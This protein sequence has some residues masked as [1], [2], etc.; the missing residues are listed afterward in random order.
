ML[1][2]VHRKV[3]DKI[4]AWTNEYWVGNSQKQDMKMAA[5]FQTHFIVNNGPE[6][7]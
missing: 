4:K 6:Q 2:D 1:Q 3:V 5:R 7:S